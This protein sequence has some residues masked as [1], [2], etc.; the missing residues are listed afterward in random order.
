LVIPAALNR[1]GLPVCLE[2]DGPTG[3]DSRLLAIGRRV[4]EVLGHLPP[5]KI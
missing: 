3:S 2:L 5:P 1:E 4:E